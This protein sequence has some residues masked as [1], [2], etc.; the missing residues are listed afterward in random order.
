MAPNP[1]PEESRK[2]TTAAALGRARAQFM[3]AEAGRRDGRSCVYEGRGGPSFS[4]LG[5]V[6]RNGCHPFRLVLCSRTT[7]LFLLV[8]W[9]VLHRVLSGVLARSAGEP[10]ARCSTKW[11]LAMFMV[12]RQM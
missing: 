10:P 8:G 3:R 6:R 11:P 12:C 2:P 7:N 4:C 9:G 1:S 5:G